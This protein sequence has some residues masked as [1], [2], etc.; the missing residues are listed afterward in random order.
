MTDPFGG[1]PVPR[2]L[3]CDRDGTLVADVPY[4]HDPDLVDPLPGVADALARARAAGLA[5]AVVTNQSGVA[6]GRIRPDELDA[7]HRRLDE[8]LGP[9]DAIVHCP[10]GPDDG[11]RCRKPQP[12]MVLEAAQ[13]LGVAPSACVMVGDTKADVAAAYGAGAVGILVPNDAT[14]PLE[15]RGVAHVCEDFATAVDVVLSWLD[16]HEAGQRHAVPA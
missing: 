12:G 15:L 10:H 5:V 6:T 9:F 2:A 8:V 14:M 13:R 7:V 3:L 11:C 4:N 1:P 16:A